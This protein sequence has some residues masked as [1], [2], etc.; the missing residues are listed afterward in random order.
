MSLSVPISDH[1]MSAN[2]GEAWFRASLHAISRYRRT[3]RDVEVPASADATRWAN[4]YTICREMRL[5]HPS[6][7]RSRLQH[8]LDKIVGPPVPFRLHNRADR[9]K[10]KEAEEAAAKE[11]EKKNK[12]K[13]AK[14]VL[15]VSLVCLCFCLCLCLCPCLCL[16]RQ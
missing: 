8:A 1:S 12:E 7:D 2:P 3:W 14:M 6:D 10:Q 16:S 9:W 11:E 13:R 4:V 15:E 5:S